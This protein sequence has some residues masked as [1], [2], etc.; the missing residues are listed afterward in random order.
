MRHY[1]S[2]CLL[3]PKLCRASITCHSIG[4]FS[5]RVPSGSMR[6]RSTPR[7][8]PFCPSCRAA[9][10]GPRPRSRPVLRR[11]CGPPGRA[12][13][14]SGLK[15]GR[16]RTF[17]TQIII[18]NIRGFSSFEPAHV[19]SGLPRYRP[20]LC[21]VV[22]PAVWCP[23]RLTRARPFFFDNVL[24]PRL[25]WRPSGRK[26]RKEK[27]CK[28]SSQVRERQNASRR[29]RFGNWCGIKWPPSPPAP[30]PQSGRKTGRPVK[31]SKTRFGV[32]YAVL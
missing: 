26:V 22:G 31:P 4:V 18:L 28:H 10:G 2:Y 19:V 32:P 14:L 6:P 3:C 15:I 21:T 8:F 20:G 17:Y 11:R 5:S 29:S 9:Y 13:L 7:R 27:G 23:A 12:F 25:L 24:R 16:L 1:L 30:Y